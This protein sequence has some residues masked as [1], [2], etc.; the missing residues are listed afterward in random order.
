MKATFLKRF[1]D[2]A[3]KRMIFLRLFI[4]L[5]LNPFTASATHISGA[6]ITYRGSVGTL[7]SCH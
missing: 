5:M 7:I 1:V 2:L 3:V 4:L 6:D